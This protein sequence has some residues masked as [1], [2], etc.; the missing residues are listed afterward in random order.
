MRED[1]VLGQIICVPHAVELGATDLTQR[2]DRHCWLADEKELFE[3]LLI[4]KCFLISIRGLKAHEKALD[5]RLNAVVIVTIGRFVSF[6]V[7]DKK[8]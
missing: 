2:P 6:Y 4:L 3:R 1:V 5:R 8:I 7:F